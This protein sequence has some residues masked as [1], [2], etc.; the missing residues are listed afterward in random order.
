VSGQSP[1]PARSLKQDRL[2]VTTIA[3]TVNMCPGH[4]DRT[5]KQHR[6][7]EAVGS[8]SGRGLTVAK[9][10][11]GKENLRDLEE[12]CYPPRRVKSVDFFVCLVPPTFNRSSFS[13]A[14]CQPFAKYFKATTAEPTRR[15][16]GAILANDC[17]IVRRALRQVSLH[18]RSRQGRPKSGLFAKGACYC[19]PSST[20][21]RPGAMASGSATPL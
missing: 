20:C 8:V 2:G 5:L 19:T 9:D 15:A 1:D 6:A 17:R 13:R 21:R 10:H 14:F 16:P 18:K 11:E 4:T 12:L 3:R 7:G